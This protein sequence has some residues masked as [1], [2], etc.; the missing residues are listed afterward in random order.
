MTKYL[1]ASVDIG[2]TPLGSGKTIG[3]SYSSVSPL[4]SSLLKNSLTLASIILLG[5]LLFGGLNF[6][7]S[8]GSSDS[9]KAEQS[10]KSITS[11]IIGFAIVFCA[12]FIIQIISFITGVNILNSSL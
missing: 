6:I 5:L 4:I 3:S 8:A 12:Y 9:K 2:D 10:K 1:L 11:A 7:I